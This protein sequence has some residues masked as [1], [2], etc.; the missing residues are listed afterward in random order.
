VLIVEVIVEMHD[1]AINNGLIVNSTGMTKT[2]VGIQNGKI[3]SINESPLNGHKVIDA[4]G[5]WIIP[6]VIDAH[7]HF[8][9]KQG[10]GDDATQT[11]DD[12]ESGPIA[13][14]IG[15]VTT[16]LD[17]AI[18]PR[19]QS[20]IS[21][22]QERIKLAEQGSCIDFGFHAGITDPNLKMLDLFPQ[23]VSMGIPSF[24][25]FVTYKKWGFA[26]NLGFLFDAM[27]HLCQLG[28][29]AC[30]HCEHDEII[31]YLREKYASEN[32]LIYHSRSRPDFS[33][34]IAI[35]EVMTLARETGCR[36]FIV[37]LSTSKG[38]EAIRY[39]QSKG[40][41]VQTETCPHYLEFS[42]DVYT[43]ITGRLSVMTPP[44]RP[45]GNS[46]ELWKGV[47]DGSIKIFASDHNALGK[48]VKEKYSHWSEIPPGL[49]GSE[50]LLTYLHSQGVAQG[51]ITP[52]KM[53]ALL[54]TNP[55]SL[56][57]IKNKGKVALG[58]DADL[59]V[60]DPQLE[61]TISFQ[62]LVTPA[63]FT[64]YEG[65]KMKGYPEMTMSNGRVIVDRGKFVGQ[66]GSGK[67]V[68]R[69]IDPEA[70]SMRT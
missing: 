51:R 48:V 8:A 56:F 63:G 49:G 68:E 34:E 65:M 40:I 29:I 6:G 62:D 2:N 66:K 55:A 5:K 37:H 54:S 16:F 7:V 35:Q 53:V 47:R 25:F 42:D 44:L 41:K 31:E 36:L 69:K 24:K 18:S 11:E 58:Y 46:E 30:V 21:Y 22:L 70:W 19:T 52:E 17:Y 12:Y 45:K 9:L 28:G 33:E 67:F 60:F 26:V 23:I 13:S 10:Q 39:G 14:A 38:L 43:D 50:M 3:S 32:D 27:S 15:G 57:G 59:V 61:R 4:K 1:L 20:P 64:I